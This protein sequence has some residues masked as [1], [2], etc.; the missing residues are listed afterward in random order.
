MQK[1]K[2]RIQIYLYL[3]SAI[4]FISLSTA[5]NLIYIY[6]MQWLNATNSLLVV[7]F[8]M[9]VCSIQ[10]MAT[11][12]CFNKF[13]SF[14]IDTNRSLFSW[15]HYNE[16]LIEVI[17]FGELVFEKHSRCEDLYWP[18]VEINWLCCV[19]YI[20][21]CRW[22]ISHSVTQQQQRNAVSRAAPNRTGP[23]WTHEHVSIVVDMI[24]FP[25]FESS[26]WR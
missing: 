24:D 21:H 18:F 4:A 22:F 17:G 19:Y 8:S 11:C 25:I 3:K 10:C 13:Q 12:D 1:I 5:M 26:V 6:I 9:C 16:T 20:L 7:F 23:D 14:K 15:K 2:L